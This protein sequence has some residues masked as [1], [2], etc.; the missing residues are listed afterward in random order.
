MYVYIYIINNIKKKYIHEWG[1]RRCRAAPGRS[2]PSAARPCEGRDDCV[3]I[4]ND[5]NNKKKKKSNDNNNVVI[6]I[7]NNT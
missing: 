1:A 4:N 3:N 6:S 7:N 2:P 5:N